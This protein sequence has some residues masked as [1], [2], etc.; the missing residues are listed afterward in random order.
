MASSSTTLP[1]GPVLGFLAVHA[2]LRQ[3]CTDLVT[4]ARA[5]AAVDDRLALLDRVITAH[6]HGEDAVLLPLL[7]SKEPALTDVTERVEEQHVGLDATIERL[8]AAAADGIT[9]VDGITA[10]GAL[11]ED[12]LALEEQHLLP[13]WVASLSPADHVRFA[14]R[15]RRATPWRDIAVVVPWLLDAVPDSYRGVAEGELPRPVRFAYRHALRS[16]FER[17]WNRPVA[18]AAAV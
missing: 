12:H 3:D 4:A 6:H 8:R 17:T 9:D 13:I 2:A 15:L 5:G 16:R 18:V 11:L 1:P 10:L 7:R 14:R